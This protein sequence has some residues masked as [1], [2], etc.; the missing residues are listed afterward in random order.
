[1][2][3]IAAPIRRSGTGHHQPERGR[4]KRPADIVA[5]PD[6][7]HRRHRNGSGEAPPHSGPYRRR[8][9]REVGRIDPH[10]R[11]RRAATSAARAP[12]RRAA[13]TWPP[14]RRTRA[15]R[16]PW[17]G[18]WR[19][20]GEA[21]ASDRGA[22]G[23]GAGERAER[24]RPLSAALRPGRGVLRGR[25]GSRASCAGRTR[26]A[27]AGATPQPAP[28]SRTLDSGDL[29]CDGVRRRS[30][31]APMP[32]RGACPGAPSPSASAASPSS[33]SARAAGSRPAGGRGSSAGRSPPC[34]EAARG[35][36]SPDEP[37]AS[38]KRPSSGYTRG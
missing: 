12:V 36:C 7:G 18:P 19:A 26:P 31:A 2:A 24:R 6:P 28:G 30:R 21:V 8:F 10:D 23:L 11:R 14:S 1:M 25:R 29:A 27:G 38:V 34:D 37:P 35:P 9:G 33:A 17:S 22:V 13:P 15:R 20:L 32:R 16:R 3:T 4:R 5:E